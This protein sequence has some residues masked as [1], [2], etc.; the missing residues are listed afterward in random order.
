MGNPTNAKCQITSSTEIKLKV[1]LAGFKFGKASKF[2]TNQLNNPYN[3]PVTQ[4]YFDR[5]FIEGYTI[6]NPAVNAKA[7]TKCRINPTPAKNN[8]PV[9][10]ASP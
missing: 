2:I 6:K 9:K 8:A 5:R 10:A 3:S 4:I 7:T 1:A